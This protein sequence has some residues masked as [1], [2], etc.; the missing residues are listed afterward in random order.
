M[1]RELY[2]AVTF[3]A[4]LFSHFPLS[5]DGVCCAVL[6]S[7]LQPENGEFSKKVDA[8]LTCVHLLTVRA[9]RQEIKSSSSQNDVLCDTIHISYDETSTRQMYMRVLPPNPRFQI[10]PPVASL[11]QTFHRPVQAAITAKEATRN[12]L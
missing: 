12:S 1:I 2:A 5:S 4:L 9:L 6:F 3:F 11:E 7:S 10:C 8:T